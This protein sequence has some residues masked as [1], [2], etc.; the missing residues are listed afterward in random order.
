MATFIKKHRLQTILILLIVLVIIWL[1]YVFLRSLSVGP[2]YI[3]CRP[4]CGL[5]DKM[6]VIKNCID[7]AI[8]SNR[9]III[10]TTTDYFND[11]INVY[12]NIHSP[13]VYTGPADSILPKIMN[14]SI[15]PPGTKL[16][17]DKLKPDCL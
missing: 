17:I 5:I 6:S 10:D 14:L 2:I 11:D 3:V 12:I 13:H 16:K 1:I 7:Y 9:V 15:Y 8:K 4:M